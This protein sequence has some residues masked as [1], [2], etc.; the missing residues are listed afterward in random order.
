[1]ETQNTL[2]LHD[3]PADVIAA[4]TLLTRYFAQ[5][6][7]KGWSLGGCTDR[8]AIV[9]KACLTFDREREILRRLGFPELAAAVTRQ[10][11][12]K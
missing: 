8:N 6:D 10:D 7:M 3:I 11:G 5:R 4:E 9:D 2:N 1:M 12:T